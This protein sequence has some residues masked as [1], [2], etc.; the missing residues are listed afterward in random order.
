MSARENFLRLVARG[1]EDIDLAEA[2]LWIAAEGDSNV[3]VARSLQQLDELAQQARSAVEAAPT[4]AGK[5]EALNHSLF[6]EARFRGS[7]EDYY[8]PRN[9]FLNE[10]L[11][12]RLGIPITLSVVYV[13]VA[14]RL[15]FDAA[16]VSFP[17]HFL[18]IIRGQEPVLIDAFAGRIVSEEDCIEMLRATQGGSME[19][20]PE[21]LE[22]ATPREILLRIL[23]NLK[24][25]YFQKQSWNEALAC[26]DRM[27]VLAPDAALELRDR[28]LLYQRLECFGP[29]L[30]DLEA[31]LELAPDHESAHAVRAALEPLRA[32]ASQVH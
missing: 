18:A 30:T 19:F 22:A 9:S 28:G 2:A 24:R 27:L 20:A 14:R 15:G 6:V 8:D 5:I 17:G 29:A 25:I 7:R 16:G 26:C 21:M 1:D 12:R 3:D 11:E 23:N 13:E 10:V 4:Q 31:F 32:K